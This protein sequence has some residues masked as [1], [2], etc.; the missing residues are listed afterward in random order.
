MSRS[1]VRALA[2]GAIAAQV[3]FV[4]AWIVAGALDPGYSHIEE[5]VSELGGRDAA[6]PWIVN[7]ALVV[8]GLS[9]VAVGI[10]LCS[11]LPR[12][13]ARTVAVG[14]FVVTGVLTAAV[15]FLP[16]DCSFADQACEDAW[17]AGELSWQLDAHV[18]ISL[19]TPLLITAMPFAIA[20][21]LR[22][23]PVSTAALAIGVFSVVTT[24]IGLGLGFAE[25]GDYGFA[26]RIGLLLIH[27]W[28]FIVAGGVLYATRRPPQPGRLV[29]LRPRDFVAGEWRGEGEMVLRPLWFWRPFA[30]RFAAH[31]RT[32]WL[33]DRVFRIDDESVFAP[34][35]SQE[36][37][38]YCEFV[39][40]EL[41]RITAADLPDGAKIHIEDEGYRMTP[42]RMAFPLG[43]LPV[44]MRVRDESWV[45]TDGT[46]VNVYEA[47]DVL[48]HIPLARLSFRVRPV[49]EG[50]GTERELVA[51]A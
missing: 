1:T 19:I 50:D 16:V 17:R 35:R 48:F 31:R 13:R 40:P 24:A 25:A 47:E 33:T 7:S 32:T 45:D 38:M 39:S 22:P 4:V 49:E 6:H 10:A 15:A 12:R 44:L 20:A 41:V 23:S 26:Q 30:Q 5:G 11:V 43:P 18:W 8:F 42:F 51:S 9:F 27:G 36:R 46:F 29:P 34:G 28:I 14:L 37:T 3:A 21:A 2:V